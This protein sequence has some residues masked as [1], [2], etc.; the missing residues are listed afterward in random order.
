MIEEAIS[1]R[2]KPPL[3]EQNRVYAAFNGK[4]RTRSM[5]YL[6]FTYSV[7]YVSSSLKYSAALNSAGSHS[8]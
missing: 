8:S 7:T 5:I 1:R 2:P 4:S 6:H 3:K